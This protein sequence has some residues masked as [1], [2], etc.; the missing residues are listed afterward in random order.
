MRRRSRTPSSRVVLYSET[1]R[2]YEC[3]T[4][5][6]VCSGD[7][8]ADTCPSGN[9]IPLNTEFRW[10]PVGPPIDIAGLLEEA[11]EGL[12]LPEPQIATAPPLD[13]RMF[14]QI[15]AWFWV[16]ESYWGEDRASAETSP[17]GR[18]TVRV[19][20]EPAFAE[21]DPGDG[22]APAPCPD[23][24][25]KF[26][27]TLDPET[28]SSCI[29]IYEHTP[30]FTGLDAF[31]AE[32]TVAFELTWEMEFAGQAPRERGSIGTAYRSTTQPVE[33]TEIQALVLE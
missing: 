24:G 22:G 7:W 21:I 16:D 29:H 2:W 14:V 18:L 10:G 5:S 25:R 23:G 28:G 8:Q 31:D 27:P 32:M 17:G 30:G 20:G 13:A 6:L 9:L 4:Q 19:M 15:P 11:T 12:E 1:G 33:V 26:R 3:N